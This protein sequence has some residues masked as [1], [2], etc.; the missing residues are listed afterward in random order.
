MMI[1]NTV[2]KYH[3]LDIGTYLAIRFLDGTIIKGT[4][5]AIRSDMVSIKG[6][7]ISYPRKKSEFRIAKLDLKLNT[8]ETMIYS[9][10]TFKDLQPDPIDGKPNE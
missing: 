2:E 6:V 5:C 4:V 3:N 8:F 10:P 1:N 7:S 9:V